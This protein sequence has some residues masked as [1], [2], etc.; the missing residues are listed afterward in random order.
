MLGDFRVWQQILLWRKVPACD[1]RGRNGLRPSVSSH[2]WP[3]PGQGLFLQEGHGG[4][5][6]ALAQQSCLLAQGFLAKVLSLLPC[7]L[8]DLS[9]S[10]SHEQLCSWYLIITQSVRWL[11]ACPIGHMMRL[12]SCDVT[13]SLCQQNALILPTM[14]LD[15]QQFRC[16]AF[17]CVHKSPWCPSSMPVLQPFLLFKIHRPCFCVNRGSVG[18]FDL[19]KCIQACRRHCAFLPGTYLYAIEFL[20]ICRKSLIVIC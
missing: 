6:G 19:T 13:V 16:L 9:H 11:P 5:P 14:W 1:T 4:C 3:S 2:W 12:I 8:E 15:R 10:D 7:Y 18:C 20:S 17:S